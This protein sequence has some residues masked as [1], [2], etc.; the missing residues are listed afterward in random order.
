M[1]EQ[2]EN[3]HKNNIAETSIPQLIEELVLKVNL[4]KT[5]DSQAD[6]LGT[7]LEKIK[8]RILGEILL[9]I[10]GLSLKGNIN[11]YESLAMAL[12]T[13]SLAGYGKKSA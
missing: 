4:Y 8:S 9:T 10:T 13:R 7:E 12:Q 5:I 1:W 11:V 6:M 3:F 2:C